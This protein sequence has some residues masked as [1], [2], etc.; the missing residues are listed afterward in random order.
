MYVI[1]TFE[2]KIQHTKK[3]ATIM[4]FYIYDLWIKVVFNYYNTQVATA[5]FKQT[6]DY[7]CFLLVKYM[8]LFSVAFR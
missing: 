6:N 8:Q 1:H 3:T 5:C 2:F 4:L 7:W